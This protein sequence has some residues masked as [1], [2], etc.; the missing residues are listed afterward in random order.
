MRI[1]AAG[2][3]GASACSAA[4]T[5]CSK[6]GFCAGASEHADHGRLARHCV[7]TGLFADKRGVTFEVEQ[8]ISDLEGLTNGRSI[9][10]KRLA[11]R[12]RRRSEHAAGFAGES[13]QRAGLH[14][15]QSAHFA[16]A[17]PLRPIP[18]K[19]ALGGQIEHLPADH[20]A[21]AG[22]AGKRADEL[23]PHSRIGMRLRPGK[24]VEGEG[25]KPVA[26][27]NGGRLDRR[28]CAP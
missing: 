4:A 27:E 19:A 25:E 20:A 28:P 17:E 7:L 23:D 21:Q 11:L 6:P 15:L 13:Q 2:P 12:S 24:D 14:R 10:L 9:P 16:L 8:I 22:R 18:G 3:N 26:R 1:A 5:S